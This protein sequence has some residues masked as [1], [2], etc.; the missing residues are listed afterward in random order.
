MKGEAPVAVELKYTRHGPVLSEDRRA[1]QGVRAARGVDG[2]R[3]GAVPG[4]PAHGSGEDV[5]RVPRRLHVQPAFRRRTWCGR[6]ARATSA[7]RRWRSRRCGRTGPAC[8][9]VPGDGRYEWNGYL[10]INAL[11]HVAN[12]TRAITRR[13]TTTV[14]RR[15]IRTERRCTTP[16]PIRFACRA[17]AKCS[18]SGRLQT[19]ADMMRLQNDALSLPARSLV[20]LLRSVTIADPAVGEK[21]RDDAARLGLRPRRRI[22]RGGHLRN[23]AAPLGARTCATCSFRR[24]RAAVPRQRAEHEENHRLAARRPT[25]ASAAIRRGGATRCSRAASRKR[26]AN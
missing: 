25:A 19:V 3:C 22:G 8:V 7:I 5:G 6:I 24:K 10:P 16:A 2:N 13:R 9:P 15:T 17:S 14:S 18:A 11:P 21:A 26:S 12:P 1:S 4:E 20:P 23:V